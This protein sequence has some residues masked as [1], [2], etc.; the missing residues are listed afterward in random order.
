MRTPD[1]L[2]GRW[3]EIPVA[4]D[5]QIVSKWEAVLCYWAL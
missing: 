1:L 4:Q 3:S 2:I 5:L